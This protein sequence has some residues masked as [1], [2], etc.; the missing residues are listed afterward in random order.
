MKVG[1]LAG[2]H[3]I[4][5]GKIQSI[6]VD[7]PPEQ[8]ENGTNTVQFVYPPNTSASANWTVHTT[9]AS[10]TVEGSFQV[11]E[12]EKG[13][14]LKSDSIVRKNDDSTSWVTYS[15]DQ[16]AIPQQVTARNREQRP[17]KSVEEM[18]QDAM[19]DIGQQLAGN[20]VQFFR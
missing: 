2:L 17:L 1:Q 12:C 3:A 20:L 4:V 5:V 14:I 11:L 16:R 7:A 18:V 10:V 6:I 15:G 9:R 13:T 8:L 19:R